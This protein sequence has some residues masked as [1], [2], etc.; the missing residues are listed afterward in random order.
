MANCNCV[1]GNFDVLL[2]Y[3]SC[4]K[5]LIEDISDWMVEESIYTKAD[6]YNLIITTPNRPKS[7]TVNI[8]TDKRNIITTG[9]LGINGLIFND[10]IYCF[11]LENCG[12]TY[13]R[14][15]LVSC[16]IECCIEDAVSKL[17]NREEVILLDEIRLLLD[18]CRINTEIGNLTKATEQ[19]NMLTKMLRNLNCKCN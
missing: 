7:Y 13:T 8:K 18:S 6:S 12:N 14:N 2:G 15:K 9:D 19:Y 5:L 3:H 10:G 1:K 4:S 16:S 11:K 17:K